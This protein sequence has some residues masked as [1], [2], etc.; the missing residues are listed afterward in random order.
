[1]NPNLCSLTREKRE[2]QMMRLMP[3]TLA[4][5]TKIAFTL[6][7]CT[8]LMLAAAPAWAQDDQR[9]RARQRCRLGVATGCGAVITV[10]GVDPVTWGCNFLYGDEPHG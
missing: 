7:C 2:L 1:M 3:A 9:T 8:L 6:L 10:T 5:V 4:A